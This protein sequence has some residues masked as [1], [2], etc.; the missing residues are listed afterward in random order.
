[1]SRRT[2]RRMGRRPLLTPEVEEQL[3]KATASGV[4]VEIAAEAAGIAK[5]TFMAWLQRGRD[6]EERLAAAELDG[7]DPEHSEVNEPYLRLWQRVVKA[8]ATAATR[9]V[10]VIQKVAAGGSITEE[11]EETLPDGTVRKTV[12]RQP[13][14]WRAAAWHLERQHARQFG[15]E[16][17]QV[18]LSGPDGGPVEV[19][20][21]VDADALAAR[22]AENIAVLA[23]ASRPAALEAGD[24]PEVYDAEV[25]ED[26]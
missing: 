14:D 1:M 23:A 11:T 4:P 21:A 3:V 5:S 2:P 25:I 10:L 12:K 18:E 8:R 22:L 19:G 24:D 17:M 26:R 16:A 15:K 13:P 6:E 7:F 20:G 9:A